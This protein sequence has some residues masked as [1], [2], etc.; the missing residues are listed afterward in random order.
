MIV[1]IIEKKQQDVKRKEC[2][3][4]GKIEF[5]RIKVLKHHYNTKFRIVQN[6]SIFQNIP[7][8]TSTRVN[9]Q[10]FI[11]KRAPSIECSNEH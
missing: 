10:I 5:C 6:F 7:K 9:I 8:K 11:Q 4:S 2:Y 3:F 1:T